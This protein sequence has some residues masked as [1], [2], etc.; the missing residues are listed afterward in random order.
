MTA[1]YTGMN[2]YKPGVVHD[3]EHLHCSVRDIL[4]TPQGSRIM[5]R[6]YGSLVPDLLDA[7]KNDT[8]RLQCMSA[9]VIALTRHEPRLALNT[10]DVCWLDEG[11]AE[12]L[13]T[14]IITATMQTV[15][16]TVRTGE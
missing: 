14:G 2:P 1:T 6:D 16:L 7:P 8:T 10:I 9:A 4:L 15:R 11:G 3:T 5:R 12:L 13:L